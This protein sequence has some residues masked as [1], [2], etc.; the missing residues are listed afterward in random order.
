MSRQDSTKISDVKVLLKMGSNGSGIASIEKTGSDLNVDTYTITLDDGTKT[1]FTVTNGTSIAS[2]EKTGTVGLVDTYTITLTDGSTSTFEVVNGEG[3]TAS[4]VPYDNTISELTAEN[5]Q[6]AI[7]EIDATVDAQ[8]ESI[9]GIDAEIAEVNNILGAKNLCPNYAT[10]QTTSGVTYTIYKDGSVNVSGT[11]TTNIAL[12]LGVSILPK[13]TYKLTTGQ[14]VEENARVSIYVQ[15]TSDMTVIGRSQDDIGGALGEFTLLSDTE[16]IF[17]VWVAMRTG[18]AINTTIYP[19]C[20]PVS[21][22]SN[23]YIPFVLTNKQLTDVITPS[24]NKVLN[25]SS[26]IVKKVGKIVTV[27]VDFPAQTRTGWV[28]VATGLPKALFQNIA[29][30]VG[31][32][33]GSVDSWLAINDGGILDVLVASNEIN[34]QMA[35]TMTYISSN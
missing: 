1:T 20:K 21:I 5:V 12:T 8:G 28:N 16:V 35:F 7:D 24:F 13:G 2:I 3:S 34:I 22:K 15:R 19:M 30:G 18:T 14:A 11:P 9:E 17:S 27:R 23:T 31:A 26:V 4:S 32:G 6:D 33:G 10:T 25:S 29:R